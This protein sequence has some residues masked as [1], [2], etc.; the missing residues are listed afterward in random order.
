M[1]FV[2]DL[3]W[4][5]GK[6]KFLTVLDEGCRECLEIRSEKRMRSRDVL[7]LDAVIE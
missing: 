2:H 3:T 1:D 4:F 7:V 5:G 6:V